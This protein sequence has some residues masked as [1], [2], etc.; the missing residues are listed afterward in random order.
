MSDNLRPDVTPAIKYAL[1]G[2][3][4]LLLLALFAGFVQVPWMGAIAVWAAFAVVLVVSRLPVGLPPAPELAK[5][6]A[7]QALV[8]AVLFFIG[9][10]IG[11]LFFSGPALP[12]I[13]VAV[14]G[15]AL[16]IA[17]LFMT[18]KAAALTK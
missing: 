17:A 16:M 9:R 8:V 2:T 4:T 3:S 1:Y 12:L 6:L 18:Q 15:A 13:V 10:A 11:G 5:K 14:I 7:G